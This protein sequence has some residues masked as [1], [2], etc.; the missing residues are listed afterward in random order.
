MSMSGVKH[1]SEGPRRFDVFTGA[2]AD[3]VS[4]EPRRPRSS[5]RATPAGTRSVASHAATA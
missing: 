2:G 4:R 5:R 1:V 3:A